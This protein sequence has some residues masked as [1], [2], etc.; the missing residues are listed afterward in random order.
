MRKRHPTIPLLHLSIVL[1]AF[2]G[3]P[4][5][6]QTVVTQGNQRVIVDGDTV[7]IEQPGGVTVVQGDWRET[8]EADT[9]QILVD[10]GAVTVEDRI[11]IT[12]GES[13]LFDFGSYAVRPDAAETLSQVAQVVRGR[14][15]GTVYLLGHTDSI[16]DDAYNRELSRQRAASVMSWLASHEGIPATIMVGHGM[17]SS[18]PVAHNTN[19]DGSD[20]SEGRAKN[21]RVEIQMA[22]SEGVSVGPAVIIAPGGVK[23]TGEG[24]SVAGGAVQVDEG[25][26]SVGGVQVTK[27]GVRVGGVSVSGAEPKTGTVSAAAGMQIKPDF[28]RQQHIDQCA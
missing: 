12:L 14:S 5:A 21:R 15:V 2:A 3:L 25:G 19:P 28:L 4:A 8:G 7:R 17:G 22:T 10:L 16:G 24:V 13:V 23:I 18:R 26:V 20:Y 11:Q 27:E 1:A 6:A 9:E